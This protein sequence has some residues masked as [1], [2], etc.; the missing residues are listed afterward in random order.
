MQPAYLYRMRKTFYFFLSAVL[1]S[2]TSCIK[3]KTYT[4]ECTYVASSSG[5]NSGQPNKVERESLKTSFFATAEV[6]CAKLEDKYSSQHYSG[7]C[8]LK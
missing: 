3:E 4:C 5:P 2:T 7:S 1:L 8:L 6:D